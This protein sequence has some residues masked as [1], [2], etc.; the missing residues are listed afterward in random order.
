MRNKIP[1]TH[2]K[3]EMML[4]AFLLFIY[5]EDILRE[6]TKVLLLMSWT[7]GQIVF[8]VFVLHISR[9]LKCDFFSCL[10]FHGLEGLSFCIDLSCK[11]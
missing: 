10:V 9:N 2:L 5:L 3:T 6:N 1:E 8:F 7:T 11:K 4:V